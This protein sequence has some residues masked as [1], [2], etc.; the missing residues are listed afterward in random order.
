MF[1]TLTRRAI[2]LQQHQKN[3]EKKLR[4]KVRLEKL[5]RLEQLSKRS[6]FDTNP[7]V[8][9][10]RDALRKELWRAENPNNR[11]V[12]VIYKGE[13]I[14]EGTKINICNKCKKTRGNINSLIRTGGR[15]DQGR[16]Y[17]FK[18]S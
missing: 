4:R 12:E 11:I 15:D 16:T 10:E 8:I 5:Y 17:R 6:D 18:E 13:V 3:I 9:L 2:T 7:A 14:Y 1:I